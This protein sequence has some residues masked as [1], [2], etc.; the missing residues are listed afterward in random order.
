MT[1]ENYQPGQIT[2]AVVAVED[3]HSHLSTVF[4]D[5]EVSTAN[6]II[7]TILNSVNFYINAVKLIV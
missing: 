4:I 3:S 7:N 5:I 6:T 2:Q 1:G